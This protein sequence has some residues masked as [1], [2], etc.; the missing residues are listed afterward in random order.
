[1][2]ANAFQEG[3]N[4]P[5][6]LIVENEPGTVSNLRHKLERDIPGV[7]VD[8][9]YNV[10]DA[11]EKLIASWS[12][13]R[14]PDAL[15]LD[16]KLPKDR[17]RD[18]PV[19][20]VTLG[21]VR[22]ADILVIHVTAWPD[23]PLFRQMVDAAQ[24]EGAGFRLAFEKTGDW[25]QKVADACAKHIRE[26]HSRRIRARFD[27]LFDETQP[28]GP[29]RRASESM[30]GGRS[31]RGWGLS[32]ALFCQ[33]AGRHWND[34]NPELQ[35]LLTRTVGHTK[36]EDRDIVGVVTQDDRVPDAVPEEPK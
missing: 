36:C 6:I 34:L 11:H 18:E 13:Q 21:F 31:D 23:D 26:K 3:S 20:N 15:I 14:N 24:S 35:D 28:G 9:A 19:G 10:A 17:Q 22:D 32:F 16:F 8:A 27:Q 2:N 1:M 33:D 7:V 5:Y 25:A 29:R 12:G 30:G 4:A